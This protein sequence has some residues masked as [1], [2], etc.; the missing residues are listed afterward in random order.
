[1]TDRSNTF[2]IYLLVSPISFARTVLK[3]VGWAVMKSSVTVNIT[4]CRVGGCVTTTTQWSVPVTNI[5][6]HR[7]LEGKWHCLP[8]QVLIWNRRPVQQ[9]KDIMEKLFQTMLTCFMKYVME[10]QTNSCKANS[11][12][13]QSTVSPILH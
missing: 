10:F 5:R 3:C 7:L 4:Q 6:T 1:M 11:I 2:A 12:L 8:Q 13:V 9:S